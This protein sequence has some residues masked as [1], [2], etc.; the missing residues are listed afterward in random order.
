MMGSGQLGGQVRG[1]D[2]SNASDRAAAR[3]R[4]NQFNAQNARSAYAQNWQEQ[5]QKATGQAS[6]QPTAYAQNVGQAGAVGYLGGMGA[7][8]W[9]KQNKQQPQSQDGQPGTYSSVPP[10]Y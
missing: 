9:N 7:D 5:M 1:Q 10:R 6:V 8:W 4:I 3:D 2:W